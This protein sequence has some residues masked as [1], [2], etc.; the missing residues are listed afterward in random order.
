[1]LFPTLLCLALGLAARADFPL[2][3]AEPAARST[4]TNYRLPEDF[5]PKHYDVEV[6]PYFEAE[7]EHEAF[8]FDGKVTIE[9]VV[10][11]KCNCFIYFCRSDKVR[12]HEQY[13]ISNRFSLLLRTNI[14][15]G[16][17]FGYE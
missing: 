2:E 16:V 8:T 4:D 6:T 13:A 3:Y 5:S 12:N 11:K 15:A 14:I 9:V 10:S 17:I 1:M 7:G